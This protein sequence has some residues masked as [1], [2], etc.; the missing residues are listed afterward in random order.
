MNDNSKLLSLIGLA[1]KA[2]RI[3]VGHDAVLETLKKKKSKLI[4]LASDSSERLEREIQR[5]ADFAKTQ[6]EIIRIAETMA[7][8]GRALPKKAGVISVNDDSF[9]A[10]IL[11]VIKEG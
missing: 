1:K 3:S 4:I 2:G 6:V 9:A 11:K 8:I 10:G 7:D 5:E